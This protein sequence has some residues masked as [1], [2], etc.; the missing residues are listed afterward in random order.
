ML[1]LFQL[2]TELVPMKEIKAKKIKDLKELP[3]SITMSFKRNQPH[4]QGQYKKP[5]SF[6]C[7]TRIWNM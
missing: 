1:G 5:I 6:D 3:D 2:T 4:E 7:F